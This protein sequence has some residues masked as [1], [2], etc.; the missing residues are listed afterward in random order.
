[1]ISEKP[2]ALYFQ[3]GMLQRHH[4][5]RSEYSLIRRFILSQQLDCNLQL[6]YA[7]PVPDILSSMNAQSALE[8]Q[9]CSGYLSFLLSLILAAL[10]NYYVRLYAAEHCPQ[11]SLS[12]QTSD[13]GNQSATG[14]RPKLFRKR[15]PKRE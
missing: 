10:F 5:R 15:S 3:D 14:K 12:V 13:M 9:Y 11:T 4:S 1:M 8:V 7:C 6:H 2:T